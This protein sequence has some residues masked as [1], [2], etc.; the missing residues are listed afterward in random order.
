MPG[1]RY[2]PYPARGEHS[3][4]INTANKGNKVPRMDNTTVPVFP[5][6]QLTNEYDELSDLSDEGSE[7]TIQHNRR[8]RKAANNNNFKTNQNA[9]KSTETSN[10]SSSPPPIVV[11]N[12]KMAEL[13]TKLATLADD[14]RSKTRVRIT[15]EGAKIYTDDDVTHATVMKLC[16][17]NKWHGFS[18]TP[19]KDRFVKFCLYG[20][21]QMPVEALLEELKSKQ[22]PPTQI[23]QM[24]I[25]KKRFE[26]E[27]IYIL[28]YK[29][30]QNIRMDN[31]RSVVGLFNVV[32]RFKYYKN[33]S[34]QPTQC[35]NCQMFGHGGQNC[36]N[37]S[38]C[39]RCAGSHVSKS[40]PLIKDLVDISNPEEK[41][42]VPTEKG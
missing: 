39:I 1:N 2:S 4:A 20:L 28:Y 11:Q 14:I 7:T 24:T 32:V 29:R 5:G 12:V 26:E 16:S 18:Y 22:I 15:Q 37:P 42:I 34:G 25:K 38:V 9:G 19:K 30:S 27:A 23:R 10:S 41:I 33:L 8:R 13:Q 36:F 21:W 17:E 35:S 40:C 31:L 6:L 3:R